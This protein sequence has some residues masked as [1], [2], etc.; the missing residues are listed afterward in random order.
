M[1]STLLDSVKSQ[2][3]PNVA[4]QI[5][6]AVGL[7]PNNARRALEGIAPALL[8]GAAQTAST[9][10]GAER[11]LALIREVLGQGDIPGNFA[12]LLG[13]GSLLPLGR[14]ILSGLFGSR[15]DTVAGAIGTQAGI[16]T[17]S[18]S[19]L[20]ATV[21]PLV[22]GVLGRQVA[23]KGLSPGALAELLGSERGAIASLLP[24][25]L[26]SVLGGGL[27]GLGAP[28]R[29]AG[30]AAADA[31]A[32]GGSWLRRALPALLA[33][34]AALFLYSLLRSPTPRTPSVSSP[35]PLS[36]LSLPG[37]AQIAVQ[38][39]SINDRLARFLAGSGGPLPQRFVFD[40]L[41]FELGSTEPTAASRQTIDNLSV[42]LRAYPTTSIL[43]EGH[44]DSTGDPAAN[45]QLSQAR[46]D[47]V[48]AALV[49]SGIDGSRIQ[50]QGVGSDQ[51]L[52]SN[53]SEEGRAQN[54]RTELVVTAR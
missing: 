42:I 23:Q 24:P 9:Q 47:A 1:P 35:P 44:T 10:G 33:L 38:A 5:A 26:S 46:A 54:R 19:S 32:T 16:P 6:N 25:G 12:S 13:S 31:A 37:G 45:K 49:R 17:S 29:A 2:L 48:K 36:S 52:A 22:L 50:T 4:N 41:N 40:D 34:V 11:L 14:T 27:A 43:L 18:A 15:I 30:A 51:P 7:D 53:D 3:G 20:L 39:N 21:A 28:A 8:A